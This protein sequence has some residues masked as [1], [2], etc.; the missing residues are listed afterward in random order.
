MSEISRVA[1]F[2]KLNRSSTRRSKAPPSSASCAA[3]RTSRSCTG[4]PDAADATT[5]TCTRIVRHYELDAA[6]LA[7]DVTAALDRLPRGA[8]SIS[9]F[10][11]QIEDAIERGLGLRLAACSATAQ[12]RTGYLMLGMLKTPYLRNALLAISREFEKIK[13]EDLADELGRRRR[14]DR[15]SRAWAAG[16]QRPV[17]RRSPAR[18]AGA[19]A[20]AA[21]GK[22]EALKKYTIDL[23]EQGARRARSIR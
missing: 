8:T 4:S 19:I 7:R 21:M 23:T 5:P 14:R 11:E 3:I 10:S 1:L 20:P 12:V 17:G 9:D 13:V 6:A 22:Q 15:P 16:R 18:R 2:G